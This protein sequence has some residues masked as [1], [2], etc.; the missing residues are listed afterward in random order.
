MTG[1]FGGAFPIS[2]EPDIAPEPVQE[3]AFVWD[4][5]T[6]EIVDLYMVDYG[7]NEG[8]YEY[9]ILLWTKTNE[10]IAGEDPATAVNF[11]L[12]YLY[13]FSWGN[14]SFSD[15]SFAVK[16]GVLVSN[17]SVSQQNFIKLGYVA[18]FGD[19]PDAEFYEKS[20]DFL[21][22]TV[23]ITEENTQTFTIEFEATLDDDEKISG[24]YSGGFDLVQPAP[25]VSRSG[26][27][28][29]PKQLKSRLSVK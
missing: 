16:P 8:H 27:L 4:G 23:V 28:K 25:E 24:H 3:N 22:G 21:S 10:E 5:V 17:P 2:D 1:S 15:G 7:P 26:R 12:V 18:E 29:S 13:A 6:H 11:H 14:S 9:D 19:D 20:N